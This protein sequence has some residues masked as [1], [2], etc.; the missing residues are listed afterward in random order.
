MGEPAPNM[1]LVLAFCL[2]VRFLVG[3]HPYSG[4][5]TPP[6]YGDYEA[7][8][9]WMEITLHTPI[10]EWYT[11]SSTN[12]LSHWG[13]DYPPLTAY[14]SW[15][16]GKVI[17]YFDPR[18]LDLVS[19]R[20]YE[21]A[22]SKLLL[23][24]S[25]VASDILIFFPA[26]VAF[27]S[28][29]YRH[30]SKKE[31][32]WAI[33]MALLQPALLLIDH[34]HFQ[35]NC[36]SLGFSVMAAALIVCGREVWGSVC[37]CL[38][39]NHKQ[40]SLY[41]APAFF[42][43]LL[44]R[45]LSRDRPVLEVIKL[46]L[47]VVGTFGICWAPFLTSKELSLQVLSRLAPFSRGLYEDHVANFWCTSSLLIKW[48]TL[49]VIPAL[50]RL[51]AIT[52]ILAVL[53]SMLQQI[54][55]PSKRGLVYAMLNSSLGFFFFSF[56][57]HEKS[58]LLPLLPASLL[59]LEHPAMFRWLAAMAAF[60]MY[61]LLRRDG[62]SLA[63]FA[64][65]TLFLSLSTKPASPPASSASPTSSSSTSSSWNLCSLKSSLRSWKLVFHFLV[66]SATRVEAWL[67]TLSVCGAILLHLS[68]AWI[69]APQRY[70]YIHQALMTAYAF[71]HF[72]FIALFS[73]FVQ[74]L[75]P[76][77]DGGGRREC[78]EKVERVEPRYSQ[79]PGKQQAT[80]RANPHK[81]KRE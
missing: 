10:K 80:S 57:V 44:G 29:Y 28:V 8:R 27:V 78:A 53:P 4:Q 7:Q 20:G 34:G 30:R 45:C 54:L 56:Q 33:A 51:C 13:L 73:N 46:G 39:L 79:Q 50:A 23:R 75:E 1:C 9:H 38:A 15:V 11:N 16:H 41:F 22:K 6:K 12:D 24:W 70:P 43:H 19:S 35:Y 65:L 72:V 31:R 60:S 2:L 26:V 18:A 5:N 25:V 49:F 3:L 77:D 69:P 37:F 61:P 52:T 67:S 42:G 64:T 59:A 58:I 66:A 47:A 74:C 40:M 17:A 81:G 62:L 68:A 71:L 76:A 55:F 21:S 32:L 63:Y 36:I 48:K 14:Q